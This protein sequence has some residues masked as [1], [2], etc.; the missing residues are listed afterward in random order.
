M[1][2]NDALVVAQLDVPD[3]AL[4]SVRTSDRDPQ[5]KECR[6]GSICQH[7]R[8][9]PPC[10]ER[11]SEAESAQAPPASNDGKCRLYRE[12][13]HH[14]SASAGDLHPD[15]SRSPALER[16][17]VR[18]DCAQVWT[19]APLWNRERHPRATMAAIGGMLR[20]GRG[21]DRPI[22][23]ADAVRRT[24]RSGTAA[25]CSISGPELACA[26]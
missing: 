4:T 23:S 17:V 18:S 15:M 19:S 3:H 16:F 21:R 22:G 1:R 20:P 25:R 5:C 24:P 9:R 2:V 8:A 13:R 26:A 11:V 12:I 7:D 14:N 6:W 10:K